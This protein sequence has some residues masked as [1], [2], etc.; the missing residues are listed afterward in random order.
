MKEWLSMSLST[1]SSSSMHAPAIIR[2][3]TA[4]EIRVAMACNQQSL[5]N[6]SPDAR[7]APA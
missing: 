4:N 1:Q 6:S 5:F 7:I 2:M 3:T